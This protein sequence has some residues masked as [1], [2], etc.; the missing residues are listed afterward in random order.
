M[1]GAEADSEADGSRLGDGTGSDDSAGVPET[2]EDDD[3]DA[4]GVLGVLETGT[5]EATAVYG[6]AGM[7]SS[8]RSAESARRLPSRWRL[9]CLIDENTLDV[10]AEA[11]GVEDDDAVEAGAGVSGGGRLSE[12]EPEVEVEVMEEAGDGTVSRAGDAEGGRALLRGVRARTAGER[13]PGVDKAARRGVS[14][15]ASAEVNALP[16][17]LSALSTAESEAAEVDDEDEVGDSISSES[18]DVG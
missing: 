1:L 11:E 3:E 15:G 8:S 13:P 14:G 7:A 10:E 9:P 12:S 16:K 5:A 6:V 4:T 17:M 2:D 18:T